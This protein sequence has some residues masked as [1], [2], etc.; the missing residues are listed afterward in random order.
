[1]YYDLCANRHILDP[2][3]KVKIHKGVYK[4]LTETNVYDKI[5]NEIIKLNNE[6]KYQIYIIGHSLGGALASL[7]GYLLSDTYTDDINVISFA[8]PRVGNNNWKKSFEKKENLKHWRVT[9]SRDIVTGLPYYGYKHVGC[10]IQ[11]FKDDINVIND[12]SDN[13][14]YD[15]SIF[16]CWSS[17]DHYI[18]SYYNNLVKN[19]DNNKLDNNAIL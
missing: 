4:Q 5:A 16:R 13:S 14:W 3:K 9:N 18:E 10:N 6:S 19:P 11:L 12:Y 8:S 2:I 7:F 17:T 15:F 1:M